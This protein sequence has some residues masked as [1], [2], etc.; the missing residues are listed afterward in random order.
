M[1]TSP[2]VTSRTVDD[3]LRHAS[4]IDVV[5]AVNQAHVC[6][7]FDHT[8]IRPNSLF[9]I[10]ASYSMERFWAGDPDFAIRSVRLGIEYVYDKARKHCPDQESI[11]KRA[12]YMQGFPKS[13][14]DGFDFSRIGLNRNFLYAAEHL[15]NVTGVNKTMVIV[16]RNMES[17]VDRY[18]DSQ[19]MAGMPV[20]EFLKVRTGFDFLV[21]GNELEFAGE[22]GK[23]IATGIITPGYNAR[24]Y[25]GDELVSILNKSRVDA[26]KAVL[27][28]REEIANKDML[29]ARMENK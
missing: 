17:L 27:A 3:I 14:Y 19:H 21:L 18:L 1:G 13:Y 7:D 10:I 29:S 15:S 24:Q 5:A 11:K 16:T 20:R 8:M 23:E 6:T 22:P 12:A 4:D 28:Y 2:G 9:K 25:F 26:G